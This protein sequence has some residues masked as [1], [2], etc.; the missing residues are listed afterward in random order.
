MSSLWYERTDLIY[1]LMNCKQSLHSLYI[2]SILFHFAESNSLMANKNA[3]SF[4][5]AI[6]RNSTQEQ[7][8]SIVLTIHKQS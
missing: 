1:R 5:N 7:R 8:I 6:P 3:S 2:F 4:L